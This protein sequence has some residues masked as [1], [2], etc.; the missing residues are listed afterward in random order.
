MATVVSAEVSGL[1]GNPKTKKIR[2]MPDVTAIFG[3]NGSGKTSLLKILNSALTNDSSSLMRVPFTSARVVLAQAGR[4]YTCSITKKNVSESEILLDEMVNRLRSEP[5]VPRYEQERIRRLA[6]QRIGSGWTIESEDDP[7]LSIF[8]GFN[9]RYLPTS[10]LTTIPDRSRVTPA[11]LTEE[12]YDKV[13]ADKIEALWKD[14]AQQELLEER[15]IQ[16]E[17]LAEIFSSV[18]NRPSDADADSPPDSADDAYVTLMKFFRDQEIHVRATKS[19]F[20]KNYKQDPLLRNVVSLITDVERRVAEAHAPSRKIESLVSALY[21]GGKKVSLERSIIVTGV[22]E[23]RIPI[24]LLSSGEKQVLYI[25]LE[26]LAARGDVIIIDEP[27]LSMHVDW[28]NA[29]LESMQTVN[30]DAQII[31]ATHSPEVLAGVP[32]RCVKEL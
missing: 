10:R 29:L 17:G 23:S 21:T 6:R 15:A 12:G 4:E 24:A 16:Q 28:Q 9:H 13:F 25:L 1:A 8:T 11:E 26:T 3:L 14:Y 18:L 19:R 22:D 2:F 32:S 7:E 30:S 31:L 27:E 5:G 20:M